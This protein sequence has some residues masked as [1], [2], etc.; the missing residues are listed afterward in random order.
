MPLGDPLLSGLG[1]TAAVLA[2]TVGDWDG[3]FA[4]GCP[5][6][7]CRWAYPQITSLSQQLSRFSKSSILKVRGVGSIFRG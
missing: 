1:A 3:K 6:F 7:K 5:V 2:E 4:N